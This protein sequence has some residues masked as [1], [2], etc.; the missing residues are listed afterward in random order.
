MGVDLYMYTDNDLLI[1]SGELRGQLRS[2]GW[3]V[4]YVRDTGTRPLEQLPEGPLDDTLDVLGWESSSPHGL[5]VGDAIDSGDLKGLEECNAQGYVGS[6]GFVAQCSFDFEKELAREDE[7]TREEILEEIEP[8]HLEAMRSAKL[9]YWLCVRIR[10]SNLSYRFLNVVW[11]A[12][13]QLRGG[14]LEDPQSGEYALVK[15]VS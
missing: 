6:C 10:S 13:G 2:Q 11:R 9:R 14:L 15:L 7:E 4:R 5:K 12:V 1:T 3:D 8:A